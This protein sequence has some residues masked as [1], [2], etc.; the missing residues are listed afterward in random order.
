[1]NSS[2]LN[3]RDIVSLCCQGF[4]AGHFLPDFLTHKESSPDEVAGELR[5]Y[6]AGFVKSVLYLPKE[7]F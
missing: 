3:I 1:M 6:K 5:D 2:Q 7:F 4:K